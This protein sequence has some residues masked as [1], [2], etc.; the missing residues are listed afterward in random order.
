MSDDPKPGDNRLKAIDPE[1]LLVL[2][3]A[4]I[5]PLLAVQYPALVKRSDEL[6]NKA[7][8]WASTHKVDG[9][10]TVAD[11]AEMGRAS[12]LWKQLSDFAGDDGEADE[13]RKKVKL[14]PWK[15]TQ[16]ID[17]WFKGL[18]ERLQGAMGVIHAA[19][20]L[21][22]NQVREE[23]RLK[24]LEE[25]R[26]ADALALQALKEAQA[27]RTPEAI[28]RAMKAEEEAAEAGT[29]AGQPVTDLTRTRSTMGVTTSQ[30]EKWTFTLTNMRA[31]CKAI[32][33]GDV[34]ETF[35]KPDDS[36]INLALRGKNG[37]RTCPGLDIFPTYQLNRRGA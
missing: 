16:A 22:A 35:V 9:K 7:I 13:V 32:A 20:M 4:D 30:S 11:D 23:E 34:P 1:R 27:K 3:V 25:K 5:H 36:A 37:R 24:L 6:L 17:S 28:D 15:A 33:D 12:E 14:L 31:L 10:I 21:R 26:Q 2:E 19:Q 29:A 8:E 18:R